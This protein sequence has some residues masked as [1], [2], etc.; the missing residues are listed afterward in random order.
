MKMCFNPIDPD[1]T[2]EALTQL[3]E[4]YILLKRR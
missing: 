1:M 4:N 2:C 3:Q